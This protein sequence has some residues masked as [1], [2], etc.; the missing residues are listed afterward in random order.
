MA[1]FF[2]AAE[3]AY[4]D[5]QRLGRLATVAGDGRPQKP[6]AVA[7]CSERKPQACLGARSMPSR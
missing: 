3:R 6:C 1:V 4:L 7:R 2:S 5:S